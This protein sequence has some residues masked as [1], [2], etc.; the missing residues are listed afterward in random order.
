[1]RFPS[2]WS[3][4]HELLAHHLPHLRPAQRRGLALWV[5]GTI[6]AQSACQNA[7][8]AALLAVGAWHGLRDRLREWLYDG[9][10]RAAPCQTQLEVERCFAPLLR[11]VLAWW[12]GSDLA[13][14]IDATA[15]GERV[16]VLVIS[17]LYRGSAIPVAW[18]VLPANQPGAWMPHI[19]RLLRQLRPAVPRPMRVVVLADQGLWSPRLWK[20]V[21]DLRWHPM[22]RVHDT[23]QFQ[24]VGQQR[25]PVRQLVPGPGHAWVGHGVAFC[26]RPV[27]RQ[28]TLVVVWAQGQE[29]PWVVLTDLPPAQVGVCWYGLRVWIELGFR[30]LKGVGWQW[31]HT[32]RTAPPR[33]ARHWLVLAVATLWVL[34]YGTRAEDAEQQGLPPA[35]LARPPRPAAQEARPLH[36]HVSLFRRGLSWV[37]VHLFRGRLWRRLWLAP[38]PWPGPLPHLCIIYHHEHP[39]QEVA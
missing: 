3:H 25:G 37:R 15:H 24:P 4:M 7:V 21:R 23:I 26:A 36:R 13:L 18:H 11:W 6:L 30:V 38:E 34:A 20:R 31:Q 9:P 32:R 10:D 5:Y 19:L 14:A 39:S 17:V 8:I 2:E 27:Q 16:V 35:Q 22:V 33:V 29:R 1:M 28:G 12:Q